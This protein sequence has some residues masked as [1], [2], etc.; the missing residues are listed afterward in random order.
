MGAT[1]DP[2]STALA[3]A[4]SHFSEVEAELELLGSE[5]NMKLAKD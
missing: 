1:G 4:M 3:A 2:V 5:H